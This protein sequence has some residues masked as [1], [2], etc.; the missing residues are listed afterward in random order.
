MELKKE[1]KN[2]LKKYNRYFKTKY[3]RKD[4]GR[5]KIYVYN[6]LKDD[7]VIKAVGDGHATSVIPKY[8]D[9]EGWNNPRAELTV[10][11]IPVTYIGLLMSEN[12]YIKL[13]KENV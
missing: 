6:G 8:P 12:T 2:L 3:L 1:Q 11:R 13:E 5:V 4:N 9:I 7:E 10:D